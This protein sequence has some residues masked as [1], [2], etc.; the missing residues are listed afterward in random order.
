MAAQPTQLQLLGKH[1]SVEREKR[2]L[3]GAA[4]HTQLQLVTIVTITINYYSLVTVK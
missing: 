3:P 4:Q 2:N 1:A